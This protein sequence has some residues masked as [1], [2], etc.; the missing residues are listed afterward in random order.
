MR[1]GDRGQPVESTV[2]AP[3]ALKSSTVCLKRERAAP[4]AQKKRAAPP[5]PN[6][7]R[8][9]PSAKEMQ[10]SCN[11]I[12]EPAAALISPLRNGGFEPREKR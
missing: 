9:A 7:K 8:A 3:S 6:R 1:S 10:Q 12:K 11:K 2:A 4:S 5:A